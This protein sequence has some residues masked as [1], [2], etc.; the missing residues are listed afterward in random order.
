[1]R[2]R[3]V[4]LL[5]IYLVACADDPPPRVFEPLKYDFL[6]PLRLNV[7]G[8]DI[9]DPPP[10][11]PLDAQSPAPPGPALRQLAQDRLGVGGSTGRAVFTIDD[12]QVSRIADTLEGAMAVH[13]DILGADGTPGGHAEARVTRRTTGIGRDGLQ[14]ALY[15]M[16]RQMLADMNVELEFQIRRT[17]KPFLQ[18]VTTEAMPLPVQKQDL[19]AP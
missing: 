19:S 14:G 7:A 4:L 5:P 8:I 10:P 6:A 3:A 1:M 13:L 12:A 11:G 17:L 2:R 9:G 16:T 18:D 15:D